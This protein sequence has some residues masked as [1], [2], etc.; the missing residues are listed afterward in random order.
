MPEA[1]IWYILGGLALVA[2]VAYAL[3]SGLDASLDGYIVTAGVVVGLGSIA[4][5]RSR[6]EW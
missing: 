2:T 1:R 5:A 4:I 3:Y 6:E